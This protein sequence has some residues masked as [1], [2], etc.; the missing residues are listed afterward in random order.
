MNQ[1]LII[2]GDTHGN[3]EII[4]EIFQKENA[5]GEV[6]VVHIEDER[7]IVVIRPTSKPR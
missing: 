4:E 7:L 6:V 5:L 3:F 1:K 2:I